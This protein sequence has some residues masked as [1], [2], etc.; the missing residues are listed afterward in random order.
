ML[1]KLTPDYSELERYEAGDLD[2]KD[3]AAIS[4]GCVVEKIE[5]VIGCI[6]GL[7]DAG[8]FGSRILDFLNT[9]SGLDGFATPRAAGKYTAY[10]YAALPLLQAFLADHGVECEKL[11][12]NVGQSGG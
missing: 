7:E 11:P 10:Y 8:P 1:L 4:Y 2:Y 3:H 6:E 9:L 5:E 12:G